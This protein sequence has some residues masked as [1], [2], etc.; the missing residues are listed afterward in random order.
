MRKTDKKV[1]IFIVLINYI[2]LLRR[3]IIEFLLCR[4]FQRD[5][6]SLQNISSVARDILQGGNPR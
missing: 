4:G 3:E 1:K 2:Q 6:F 5:Q